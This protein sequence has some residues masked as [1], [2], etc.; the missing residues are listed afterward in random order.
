MLT[1]YRT[2][3]LVVLALVIPVGGNAQTGSTSGDVRN[4]DEV[5]ASAEQVRHANRAR[6]VRK[7][8]T[9]TF[10]GVRE[11]RRIDVVGD[12]IEAGWLPTLKHV[13][14]ALHPVEKRD[15]LMCAGRAFWQI[16]LREVRD[17]RCRIDLTLHVDCVERTRTFHVAWRDGEPVLIGG[18]SNRVVEGHGC[19]QN[20][21]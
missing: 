1:V 20:C 15:D 17:D 21:P 3:W 6:A 9:V 2:C 13:T 19:R 14:F 12:D 5:T 4:H 11:D 10:S 16:T 18:L 7:L 8:L